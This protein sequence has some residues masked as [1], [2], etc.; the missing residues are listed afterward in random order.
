L[1]GRSKRQRAEHISTDDL[2]IEE[3]GPNQLFNREKKSGE[4]I[5][6]EVGDELARELDDALK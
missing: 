4:V 3:I 1:T 2:L 5:S 6:Q